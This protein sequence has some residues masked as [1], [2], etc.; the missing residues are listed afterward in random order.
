[1]NYSEYILPALIKFSIFAIRFATNDTTNRIRSVDSTLL[2]RF[3]MLQTSVNQK[4]FRNTKY[5]SIYSHI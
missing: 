4:L 2:A 1:M 3:D 5:A